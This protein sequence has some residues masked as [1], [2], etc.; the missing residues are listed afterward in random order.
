MN[1]AKNAFEF[2]KNPPAD[3]RGAPFWS[4]NSKLDPQRLVRAVESM[5]AAGMGGFF[6]HARYGLKTP[7]L[8]E[9]WFACVSACVEKARE[10]GMKA[11]LY[12]EDRWP[13][14]C[15][16][17]LVTRDH[18]NLRS[19]SLR[20]RPAAEPDKD[21]DRLAAFAVELDEQGRMKSY[22]ATEDGAPPAAGS[23]IA[24]DLI[25]AEPSPWHNDGTCQ[26]ALNPKA[27]AEFIRV[28]HR[29]YA[30]RF[31]NDFGGLIPAIFM[32]EPNYA[33]G[34]S[35]HSKNTPGAYYLPWTPNLPLEFKKRRGYDIRE[36]LPELASPPAGDDGFVKARYDHRKTI[37]ELF[38]E[39]FTE[40]IGRWCGKHNIALTGHM[41]SEESLT[42][43]TRCIGA[44]MPHYEYMQW[45]GIDLLTD[46]YQTKELC[47]AKQCTSVADQ[48]GKPR[49]ITELYGC[50]GWDWP[51]EGHK[52]IG[53]WE[54][55][56]GINFRVP[57]LTHYSLAGGAK[58]D[59]PASIFSH[60][61]WWNCYSVVE[62][63]FGR[64]SYMLTQGTP[65]RDVLVI[66]PV[67]SA[68]G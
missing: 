54:F 39:N 10:L 59:Y 17:G 19:H 40:Q 4:W 41:L 34:W 7:Y 65:V 67:E 30:D 35:S 60:S 15:A 20:V 52:F 12:D 1:A 68:W 53:D 28:T 58:R 47:I 49:A 38:V 6:M 64:L 37:T 44:A 22:R 25:T 36:H 43:Q 55:A 14:G 2:W 8:S 16:G 13:S 63:Y 24:F 33:E 56:C 29:A 5:Y 3:Y 62:D 32:D 18:A 48:L 66:H 21:A 26:D 9:E 61:P 50:T 57:H 46:S 27:T 31:G 45:P 11:Y 42:S 23:T 51:L